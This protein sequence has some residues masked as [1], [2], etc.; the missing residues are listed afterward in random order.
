M[1]SNIKD[2]L[3]TNNHSAPE[4]TRFLSSL[5]NKDM[6]TG[7][8][9]LWKDG[10][11]TG[12]ISG[13]IINSIVVLSGYSIFKVYKYIETQKKK[14]LVNAEAAYINNCD[15]TTNDDTAVDYYNNEMI[16]NNNV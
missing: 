5:G 10:C 15:D 14:A 2:F 12:F 1:K 13:I 3:H 8:E 16:E 11:K 7:M 4:M 6:K 9:V